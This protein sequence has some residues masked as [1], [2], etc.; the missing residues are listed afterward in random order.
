ML[1]PPRLQFVV[2]IFLYE[3]ACDLEFSRC[4]SSVE[5]LTCCPSPVQKVSEG[6]H[7]KAQLPGECTLG[8]L[9]HSFRTFEQSDLVF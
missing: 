3:A 8:A 7:V 1:L 9:L 4:W 2:V 6:I 5:Q